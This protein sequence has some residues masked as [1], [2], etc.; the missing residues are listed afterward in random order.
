MRSLGK[1]GVEDAY[2]VKSKRASGGQWFKIRI[3]RFDD[4][5]EAKQLANRL[6]DSK[7]IKNYFVISLPRTQ[8]GPAP[9]PKAP[10]L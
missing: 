2:I 5:N 8:P 4:P 10:K 9:A 6:V 1:H 7:V 3:G